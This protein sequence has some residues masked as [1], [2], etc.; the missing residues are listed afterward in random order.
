MRAEWLRTAL[1]VCR[2]AV[3][4]ARHRG[5]EWWRCPIC[6]YHGPFAPFA[7]PYGARR[8]AVCP[9]CLSKERHRLQFLVMRQLLDGVDASALA[10]AHVAPEPFFRG[11]WRKRFGTYV[12]VDLDRP[13]V[14]VNT[15]LC[16][17]PFADES[18]DFVYASHVLEHIR[19]DAAA[20]RE[21]WRVLRRGGLAVLPVPLVG[22][23]T[24]EYPEPNPH[25]WGHWRAPARDY[26]E[27]YR[28]VFREVR[29]YDSGAFPHEHQ[30]YVY[31]EMTGWPTPEFP[32][33]QPVPGERHIDVVPVCVK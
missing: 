28:A 7:R 12:T 17:L 24:V 23:T 19:D 29:E 20:I 30:L 33:R 22:L 21:I 15:D 11:R 1:G 25:E 31:E 6:D 3:Y 14:Q 26:F 5:G 10:L 18:F 8:H 4:K 13:D 2:G 27:R 16:A 9:R 32:L